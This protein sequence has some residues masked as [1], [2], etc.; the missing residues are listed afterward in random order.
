MEER[1]SN[2]GLEPVIGKVPDPASLVELDASEFLVAA[3]DV[4]L[5]G[6]LFKALLKR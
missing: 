3:V 2:A 4:W 1:D 6:Y 5:I